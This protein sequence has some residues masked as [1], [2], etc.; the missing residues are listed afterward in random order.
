ML[1]EDFDHAMRAFACKL[2]TAYR[3]TIDLPT[4]HEEEGGEHVVTIAIVG[5][6][7]NLVFFLEFTQ[8]FMLASTEH[9]YRGDV[10]AFLREPLHFQIGRPAYI[11]EMPGYLSCE[12]DF[13]ALADDIAEIKDRYLKIKEAILLERATWKPGD[14]ILSK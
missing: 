4:W 11:D 2:E 8:F 10:E 7:I 14:L 3:C 5:E 9:D 12:E 13:L 6:K 1:Y